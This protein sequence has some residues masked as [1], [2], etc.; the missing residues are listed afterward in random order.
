MKKE[1]VKSEYE[2]ETEIKIKK[3][4]VAA[5]KEESKRSK[6]EIKAA[7]KRLKELNKIRNVKPKKKNITSSI[8]SYRAALPNGIFEVE[9]KKYSK[10]LLLQDINFRNARQ[11]DEE[12]IFFCWVD[13]LNTISPEMDFAITVNN[14]QINIDDVK[15][16]VLTVRT[17][18]K[19]DTYREIYNNNIE[20]KMRK[21]RNDIEK[22][23]YFTLSIKAEN[24]LE[25]E[26]EFD[27]IEGEIL[28]E[29]KKTGSMKSR[30]LTTEERL[31]ILHDFFRPDYVGKFKLS[32]EE[33]IT[34]GLNSK[35][36]IAPISCEIKKN[37]F[38]ID[39]DKYYCCMTI[40]KL[41]EEIADE[42]LGDITNMEFNMMATVSA[43]PIALEK[44]IRMVKDKISSL[45]SEII[46][47]KKSATGKGYEYVKPETTYKLEGAMDFLQDLQSRKQKAFATS[48]LIVASGN[49]KEE[50]KT[51]CKSIERVA[52]RYVCRCK[53]LVYQQKEALQ[54]LL[55]LGMRTIDLTRTL[56]TQTLGSISIP[57]ETQELIQPGGQFYGTNAMS[58]KIIV[59]NKRK[60]DNPNSFILGASGSGKSFKVKQ[61]LNGIIFSTEDDVLIADPEGEYVDYVR[62]M[63][64]TVIDMHENSDVHINPL[65]ITIT[66]DIDDPIKEKNDFI[67]SLIEYMLG[68]D[69]E[70]SSVLKT[71][72]LR[73]LKKIYMQFFKTGNP[74][75]MPTLVDLRDCIMEQK[76]EEARELGTIMEFYM[77]GNMDLFSYRSNVDYENRIVV[78]NT[79]DMGSNIKRLGQL[80]ICEII[81]QRVAKNRMQGRRTWVFMDEIHT[82]FRYKEA[83]LFIESAYRRFRKWE[84]GVCGI[85]QIPEDL[86]RSEKAR[87]ML[88]SAGVVVMLNMGTFDEE[89]VKNTFKISD[90]Q[91]D[92]LS[93]AASGQGL[94]CI[95]VGDNKGVIQ[96]DDKFPKENSLYELMT[97]D[98]EE[99]KE[100]ALRKEREKIK[101]EKLMRIENWQ[102]INSTVQDLNELILKI[103]DEDEKKQ[104][105]KYI[106]KI[107]NIRLKHMD[108]MD[109]EESEAE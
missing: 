50:L 58:N 21:G 95:T 85:T 17:D 33:L 55:P 91:I 60:L 102:K 86:L 107:E 92:Y 11:E 59:L 35:D 83:E 8:L 88:Q 19:L 25:A 38:V 52:D 78:F 90:T 1:A 67:L 14:R 109:E 63:G 105:I 98:P 39:G 64:G 54:Q 100:F 24:A 7:K 5:K 47:A 79:K 31:S 51:N 48:I 22:E 32:E 77:A 99:I 104:L 6:E 45:E 75:D 15:Q 9:D 103:D 97:T 93:K 74:E 71:I 12:K 66:D 3:S 37:Y 26:K 87:A 81:S 40:S 29:I 89:V 62:A 46:E 41:P 61:E 56:I 34:G 80:V 4:K 94:L 49:S 53:P 10:T 23:K 16:K 76:E 18:D 44:A 106:Q 108:E 27:R 69:K 68:E 57:Y 13:L 42:F 96:F 43:K 72:I 84:A 65:D 73:C 36:Y 28:T 82:F 101:K 30:W 2:I 20:S 70:L